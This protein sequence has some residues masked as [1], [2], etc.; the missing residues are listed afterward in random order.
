MPE[1]PDFASAA[2]AAPH[3]AA[4]LTGQAILASGGNAVEA[5]V[6]MAATVAVVY[7]HMNGLGGDGF[8]LVRE[9]GGKIHA[10]DASGPAGSL[11]TIRRYREREYDAVPARGAQ[12][13]CTVAGTVAGWRLALELSRALGGVLPLDMLLADAVRHAREGYAVSGSEAR[14]PTGEEAALY[15]VPGFA[16]A[17]LVDDRRAPAGHL[18]RDPVLA[19]TLEQLSH[20]GLGDFY[21]G[22]IG[23]EIAA[24]LERIDSPVTRRDIETYAARVVRPLALRLRD[25]TVYNLPPPTQGLTSLIMLGIFERL[26]VTRVETPDHHHALIEAF[27][28]GALIRDGLESEP[29]ILSRDPAGFLEAGV[30]DREAARVDQGRAAAF[31]LAPSTD[32]DTVWMGAIDRSGLAVSFIQSV[33]WAYGS[34][35]RLP[36]TGILWHNRGSAFSLDPASPN[37]LAPGRKPFHSLNPSL[38]AF[39]DGRVLSFGTMGGEP[40]PQIL[41]QIYT[42]YALGMGLADAVDAPRWILGRERGAWDGTLK[43]ENR[44]DPGLLRGLRGLGHPVEE[45]QDAYS[46]AFGHAGMLV[47]HPRG[48]PVEATHDPRSDGGALG[49]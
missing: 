4:A 28:R 14:F 10:F 35:C 41:G 15:E 9:P 32:G 45:I 24:D 27:K 26:G 20:A 40:Q 7:P 2:V 22:D 30:L 12:A 18:R 11:A 1:T 37:A 31:P 25:A 6:A 29:A 39:D 16:E 5:M 8:W 38:A 36:A 33:F 47:R 49:L 3:Q 46:D 43:L 13:A 17:Y 44:F 23:R 42:R 21:R 19:Q 48:G 34:G